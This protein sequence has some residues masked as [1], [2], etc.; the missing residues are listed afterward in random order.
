MAG[1]FLNVTELCP[2]YAAASY[3]I[4]NTL[5]SILSTAFIQSLGLILEQ[6][7]N[8]SS[9]WSILFGLMGILNIGG[10]LIAWRFTDATVQ[11]WA[12]EEAI[13]T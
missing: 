1:A 9:T 6:M 8:T 5:G 4:A 11:Q 3:A 13:Q 10:G 7:G 12:L 2:A